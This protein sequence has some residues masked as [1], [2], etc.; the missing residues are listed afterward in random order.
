MRRSIR[1]FTPLAAARTSPWRHLVPSLWRTMIALCVAV[2]AITLGPA[3]RGEQVRTVLAEMLAQVAAYLQTFDGSPTSPAPARTVAGISQWDIT[4]HNIDPSQTV[5]P[6]DA[7]HGSDC[8]PAPATHPVSTYADSVFQCRDHMMTAIYGANYAAIYLTPNQL[9]D[10]S[11]GTG[12]V[13]FDVS[14]LRRSDRDWI[15]LWISPYSDQL[16]LPLEDFLPD[17]Q[18]P[19]RRAV[20]I[21]M[22]NFNGQ[23]VFRTTVI[24]NFVATEY[25]TN[26]FTGYESY[27]APSPT[28]RQ[29]FELDITRT[30]LK[31][32]MPQYNLWWEDADIPD[33]GW[34]QGV[35]QLGHHSYNPYKGACLSGGCGPNTWHWDNVSISSAVPFTMLRAAQRSVDATTSAQVTFPAPSPQQANLRFAAVGT[36]LQFS[37]NG[38][39]TWQAA[40]MQAQEKNVTEHFSSFW[41]PIPA[42]VTSVLLRGQDWWGGPWMIEDISIWSPV[43]SA[44]PAATPTASSTPT[45]TS[46]PTKIPATS[47]PAVTSTPAAT[48]T[49]A[50]STATSTPATVP[51]TATATAT[52]TRTATAVSST[53]TF[54]PVPASLVG[55]RTVESSLDTNNAGTAEAFPYAAIASGSLTRLSVYLDAANAAGTVVVGLYSHNATTNS[56]GTL[57]TSGII[58][59]PVNGNWNTVAVPATSVAAGTTYWIALLSPSGGG[60][61][62]FRDSTVGSSSQ[63]SSQTT[64]TALPAT[65]LPG[66]TWPT[67]SASAYGS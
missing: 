20:H 64:L 37:I 65:W 4:V 50:A 3:G 31:F 16:Q 33:L 43:T 51:A 59:A 8:S 58:S 23:S 6:M 38:G 47:T 14:T 30:H 32:G 41:T 53:P 66:T 67:A 45:A 29:T 22:D 62:Q 28:I 12:V 44:P 25:T 42:G 61:V 40:Q 15:D 48:A 5:P 35:V 26:S 52:A 1:A 10:F 49:L 27:F 56:P 55:D 57:L 7:E 36:N 21:R 9:V 19:P 18:G 24:Q 2:A 54:T 13:K 46:T 60:V 17:L 34:N 63:T 39:A 11:S